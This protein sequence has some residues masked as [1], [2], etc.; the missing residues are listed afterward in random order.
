MVTKVQLRRDVAA[1]WTSINP[2][3]SSG[4]IGIETDT[5]KF[6]I[7]NGTST[8]T[9]LSYFGG[10]A[11]WGAIT[12]TLTDQTDLNS[13]LSGKAASSHAHAPT[14][15]TGTAVITNDSRL[16]DART[17]TAHDQAISTI[18]NLQTTLDGKEAANANIQT[19]VVSAHA[20]SNAQKNSDITK[21]E[22]EAKLIGEI[23]THTHA[24]GGGGLGYAIN[25]QALTS[26]PTDAQTVYFGTLPKAPITTAAVSRVYIPKAG[27]I[28]V[29]RIWNYSGTAGTGEAWSLYIRLNN[30]TDYLIA[31]LSL[32]TSARDFSKLDLSIAVTTS[33]YF[34]LKSVQPT[35]AT[36]PLTTIWAGLIYIE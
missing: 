28:K 8:W 14:D 11:A 5:N 32:A 2:V 34:E 17:P 3:L 9:S 6:K 26:S 15:V 31:T 20:P 16:S 18:T 10:G 13:A 1:T 21:A 25:V 22:I 30:T 19:H 24:G 27:T 4:E 12:G 36:N 33:D 7:G 35:W 29:A 23:S